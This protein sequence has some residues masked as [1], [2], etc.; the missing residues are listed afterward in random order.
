MSKSP[1]IGEVFG[2]NSL[3]PAKL[4]SLWLFNSLE[5]VIKLTA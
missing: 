3:P 2:A 1:M 4:F 5:S